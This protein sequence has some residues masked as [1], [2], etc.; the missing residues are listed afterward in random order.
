PTQRRSVS[1][2][3][4]ASPFVFPAGTFSSVLVVPIAAM[5]LP[6]VKRCA[7]TSSASYDVLS[8]DWKTTMPGLPAARV[9]AA[10]PPPKPGRVNRVTPGVGPL[11]WATLAARKPRASWLLLLGEVRTAKTFPLL[12]TVT[13]PEFSPH[14]DTSA[15]GL[16]PWP[17]PRSS[18]GFEQA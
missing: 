11:P 4:R 12:S 1:S 8:N 6:A 9:M 10:R 14:P 15:D 7:T 18:L 13:G 5:S 3:I 16:H 17:A 2:V